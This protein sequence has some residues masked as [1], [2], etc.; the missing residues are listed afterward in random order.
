[1]RAAFAECEL[2]SGFL[3]ERDELRDGLRPNARVHDHHLVAL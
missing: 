2:A 1:M 3:R